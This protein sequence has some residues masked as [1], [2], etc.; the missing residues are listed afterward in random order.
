MQRCLGCMN[1]FGKEFDICPHCGY[2]V[3]TEPENKS[4]LMPGTQLAGRYTLGKTVGHGGF[5]ITYIAWDEKIQ[6]AVAIKEFFPNAFSTRS[7]GEA[8]VSCYSR[9][10][11]E[12]LKEGIKKMLDEARRLS[13]FYRNENIVDIF[14]YFEENNT[15]YIVME[16]LEGE[17]LKKYLAERGD[18]LSPEEAVNLILPVLNALEDMHKANMIHRDISPDNIYLCTNGKVK[19]LDFGSA[20]LAVE[21]GAKSLSVMVKKGYTPQEQYASRAKQGPWTDI[22]AVCAT[23]YRAITGE[24]P[25]ES[26]E[27]DYSPL[28]KFAEFGIE[29][30]NELERIVFKG[31]EPNSAERYQ[32]VTVLAV[33]LRQSI[34]GDTVVYEAHPAP[35]PKPVEVSAPIAKNDVKANNQTAPKKNNIMRIIAV[36]AVVLIVLAGIVAAVKFMPDKKPKQDETTTAPSTTIEQTEPTTF[37][38]ESEHDKETIALYESF[39]VSEDLRLTNPA[40]AAFVEKDFSLLSEKDRDYFDAAELGINNLES[41]TIEKEYHDIDNDGTKEMFLSLDLTGAKDNIRVCL[42]DIDENG[43]IFEGGSWNGLAPTV[44]S[45]HLTVMKDK[46]GNHYFVAF[47][48]YGDYKTCE[49]F[50]YDGSS[51]ISEFSMIMNNY[52]LELYAG[53]ASCYKY[54]ASNMTLHKAYYCGKEY[55]DYNECQTVDYQEATKTWGELFGGS[56]VVGFCDNTRNA[57]NT[58]VKLT[59]S[60]TVNSRIKWE[61][62]ESGYFMITGSGAIPDYPNPNDVSE[63]EAAPWYKYSYDV[64]V[65]NVGE[66]IT[67]IG[68]LNFYNFVNAETVFL[69]ESLN[70]IGYG[71]FAYCRSVEYLS[72]PESVTLIEN[73]AFEGCENLNDIYLGEGI[74]VISKGVFKDCSS[75]SSIHI[76]IGVTRIESDAFNGCMSMNYVDVPSTVTVVEEGAFAYCRNLG[77]VYYNG[78][79]S[80]YLAL[81]WNTRTNNDAFINAQYNENY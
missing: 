19:L 35:E 58:A 41:S 7:E 66:G 63:S 2:V 60:G 17:D 55:P 38:P 73:Y 36:A 40:I 42:L 27:R 13:K 80:Q 53:N 29:G 3:G 74:T 69:P 78:T 11:E 56:R 18:R 22:Y 10:S 34:S 28:K 24:V 4:H 23:L 5:G 76:P 45:N 21:D 30:Y 62:Y 37:S 77:T 12:F 49:K 39:L 64:K 65:I 54:D 48:S 81:I 8:Q 67:R 75:L 14:D 15:A 16:Y 59:A 52:L 51:L 26:L 32:N 46:E 57:L 71:S 9:K 68:Y 43:E 33:E 6:K 25:T 79:Y 47:A 72:I 61:L 1:E 44:G 70:E 20:R 50:R 31:L